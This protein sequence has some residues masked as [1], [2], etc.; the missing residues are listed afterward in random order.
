MSCLTPDL[1]I[2]EKSYE[3]ARSN[4]ESL[5]QSL[6]FNVEKIEMGLLKEAQ[7][8][9]P[10]GS[11]KT[12]GMNLHAGN[13]TWVG[14]SHQTLQTPYSEIRHMCE[15]LNPLPGSSVVDLGAGYGRMGLV[16]SL[17]YPEVHFL[18]YEYVPERVKEGRR[19]LEKYHCHHAQLIAQDLLE[20]NFVLPQA[21]YYFLYDFG[22][23]SHIKKV[24]NLLSVISE[25]KNF[26]LI[27][28]GDGTR[29]LIQHEYPWL[30]EVYPPVHQELFSIYSMSETL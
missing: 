18:G 25:K 17:L 20:E 10:M 27:A 12:W 1:F 23:V 3:K 2:L 8:L 19:I 11:H 6:G 28:R 30:S 21:E 5:D 16:L 13:Q 29:S 14:L 26:K 24:L 7:K 22:T 15:L 4:A 9:D